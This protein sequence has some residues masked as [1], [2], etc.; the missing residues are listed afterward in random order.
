M[1]HLLIVNADDLGLSEAITDGIL[2]AHDCGIVTSASAVVNAPASAES[3]TRAVA[4][5]PRLGVGLHV[6]LT[7]GRPL[8]PAP[9]LIG[10]D[11]Q[12]LSAA[13]WLRA[14]ERFRPEDIERELGAQSDRFERLAGRRPDHLDS[15]QHLAGF[16]P[17]LFGAFLGLARALDVPVRAPW[18]FLQPARLESFC[19][20]IRGENGG[21]GPSA[22]EVADLPR[23]LARL[24]EACP[25][26]APE[27]FE[28]R[29]YGRAATLERLVGL[30]EALPPG[31]TELMCHP[32]RAE[33]VSVGPRRDHELRILC[34]TA[35]KE[36]VR[37]SSVRLVSFAE[38]RT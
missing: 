1:T 7:E 38:V 9:S 32:G 8:S 10:P 12:F 13:E 30:L 21:H 28:H 34:S 36:A 5:A 14:P 25:R 17:A 15:H 37:R 4:A 11:G 23:A 24:W 19:Q 27:H 20:R 6:N 29:F 18:D 16:H 26:P 3:I 33:P 31:L 22:E 35:V 2:E